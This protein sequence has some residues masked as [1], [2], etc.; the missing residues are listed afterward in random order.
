[1]K[2]DI[3][4]NDIST[5]ERKENNMNDNIALTEAVYYIL[6]A[7]HKPLHGYGV[8]QMTEEMSFGRVKL[9]PGTLYGALNTLC[10]KGWIKALPSETG[11][12]K[13]EYVITEIGRETVKREFMRLQELVRN[14]EKILGGTENE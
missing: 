9:A 6:L 5:S 7:L 4:D 2:T 3:S 10:G 14:G 8:M 13:K 12:R 1:M 11:D